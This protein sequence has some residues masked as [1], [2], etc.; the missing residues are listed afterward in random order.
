MAKEGLSTKHISF[1]ILPL[2]KIKVITLVIKRK[3]SLM[4]H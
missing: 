2:V 1:I 4:A 3:K